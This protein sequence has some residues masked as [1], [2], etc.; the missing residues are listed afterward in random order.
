MKYLLLVVSIFGLEEG[1]I[2]K[3]KKSSKAS[4]CH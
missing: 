2:R 3:R 1:A 4:G